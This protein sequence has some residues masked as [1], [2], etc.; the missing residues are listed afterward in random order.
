[1][2]SNNFEAFGSILTGLKESLEVFE[3]LLKTGV[4]SASLSA[5]GKTDVTIMLIKLS[6]INYSNMPNYSN[7]S[8]HSNYFR[9][10]LIFLVSLTGIRFINL[11]H[12]FFLK[13]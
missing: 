10:I 8:N 2:R 12:D 5:A 1:M 3:L 11:F 7:M 9:M 13:R 4:I 6:R